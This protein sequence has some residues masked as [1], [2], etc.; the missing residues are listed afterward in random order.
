MDGSL[1]DFSSTL[2]LLRWL[3]VGLALPLAWVWLRQRGA[4]P[5]R[6]L[7]ALTR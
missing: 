1:V 3:A 6:R 7:A 2:R 4:T 5:R